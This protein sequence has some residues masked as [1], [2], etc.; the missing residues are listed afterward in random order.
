METSLAGKTA[1][2]TGSTQGIGFG[3][4]KALAGAG[5]DVVMHGLVSQDELDQKTK[6]LKEE[7]GVKVGHNAANVRKPQEIRDMIKRTQ[8]EFGGLDILVNNVGI[9]FVSPIQDFPE[10]KWDAIMDICLN[11]AFHSTKAALPYMLEQKWGRIINTG[12]MHA[13]VASPYKSAYNAA[14]HGIAG[15]T[16]TVGL[17]VAQKGNITCNCICP[18]YV[19]T[20]LIKNQLKD[21][22]KARGIPEEKVINDVLLA[23]QPSKKFVRPEEIGALAVHLCSDNAQSFQGACISIDGGWTAR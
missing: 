2:V 3:M 1:L 10:D 12:S 5:A 9:Q 11:S 6:A 18:G 17:E 22:A 16:K 14:K 19:L 13:K 8:D 20:D 7:Y 15:L 4:L 23:D 21:T